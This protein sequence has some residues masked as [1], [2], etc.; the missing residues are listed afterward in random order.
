M[1][2][3]TGPLFI[4]SSGAS[5]G[6]ALNAAD[7]NALAVAQSYWMNPAAPS[8]ASMTL[9][10]GSAPKAVVNTGAGGAAG[11]LVAVSASH[12][13]APAGSGAQDYYCFL[14]NT[15]AYSAI[16]VTS[17]T[18]LSLGSYPANGVLLTVATSN[19]PNTAIV[20]VS[21]ALAPQ[22]PFPLVGMAIDGSNAAGAVAF[23]ASTTLTVKG[24]LTVTTGGLN[25]TAGGLA[26]AAGGLSVAAGA[27]SLQ[28]LSATTGAF[29]GAITGANGL[30]ISSGISAHQGLTATTGAFSGLLSGS[31]GLT[32]SS[33]AASL[34]ALSLAGALTSTGTALFSGA[35]PTTANNGLVSMGSGPFDGVS[36]SRYVGA[37]AGTI[38]GINS[39]SGF[40]GSLTDMQL[41]GV[42]M[43][44]I[45]NTGV[46]VAGL[47]V[48]NGA[49]TH[50]AGS[51]SLTSVTINTGL[52][53]QGMTVHSAASAGLGTAL[54]S[55]PA[56]YLLIT[57]INALPGNYVIPFYP[58]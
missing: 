16:N 24:N 8:F 4:D 56:G 49:I 48:P 35:A 41:G 2:L 11:Y 40:G 52:V 33:G 57:A 47:S 15:G 20:S 32:V 26:I 22:V 54:P 37:G 7:F 29:S 55:T 13:I 53:F 5:T 42:S 14:L 21:I 46:I 18:P 36:A 10:Y 25:V 27:T 23:P 1:S 44:K 31:A 34:Q 45:N 38:L 9:T 43:L 28:A 19:S 50:S 58:A 6:T 12:V 17:G 3:F 30:T 51:A 39:P